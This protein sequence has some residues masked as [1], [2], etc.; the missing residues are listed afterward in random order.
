MIKLNR[1]NGEVFYLN[2]DL[3]ET[4]E[5]KHNT[6]IKLTSGNKYIVKNSINEIIQ[7]IISFKKQIHKKDI[8]FGNEV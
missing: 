3:I 7:N 6:I 4:I 2:I 8:S 1:I 5:E